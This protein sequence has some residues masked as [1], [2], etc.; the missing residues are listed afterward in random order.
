MK[1]SEKFPS[2][3]LGDRVEHDTY[4]VTR[5]DNCIMCGHMTAF[6]DL[7]GGAHVCS[8]ECE[9]AYFHEYFVKY[10]KERKF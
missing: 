10:F 9:D 8:E 2:A 1:F 7:Y 6:R 4:E 5:P 3:K